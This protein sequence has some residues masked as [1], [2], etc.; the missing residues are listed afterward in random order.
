VQEL[1]RSTTRQTAK[2]ASGNIP[3]HKRHAQFMNGVGWGI[4]LAFSLLSMSFESALG[5]GLN[6]FGLQISRQVV[7]KMVLYIFCF[8]YSS[9]SLLL[10][11]LLSVLLVI[12]VFPFLSYETVFISTHEFSLL[13]MLLPIS[14]RGGGEGRASGWLV[15]GC[16][17]LG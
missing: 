4:N 14:L 16:Q 2:L 10:P 15:L 7:R 1:G 12:F 9:L 11:L 8:A 3:Y 6:S 13:P 5:Q 17:L